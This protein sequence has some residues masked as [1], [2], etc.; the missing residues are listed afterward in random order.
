[1][2]ESKPTV[3][4]AGGG[5]QGNLLN[6]AVRRDI[7]DLN[8]LFL[9]HALDPVVP[10]AC[11]DGTAIRT[12]RTRGAGAGGLD[13]TRA[14]RTQPAG[15]GRALTLLAGSCGGRCRVAGHEPFP[16]RSP[17]VV[18]AGGAGRGATSGRGGAV[19]LADRVR[20]GADER[21]PAVGAFAVRGVPLGLVAGAGA[22]PLAESCPLLEHAGWRCHG[23]R[24]RRPQLGLFVGAVPARP[25]RT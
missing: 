21:E 12:G 15:P 23:N 13:A 3:P 17:A 24:Q 10:V 20:P 9:T 19:G 25:L 6:H 2:S 7:A 4:H 5:H 11:P 1:M 18:R 14:V 16:E 22:S 8:R